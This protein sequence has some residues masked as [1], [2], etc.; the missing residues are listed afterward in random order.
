MQT[1]DTVKENL[2]NA[3]SDVAVKP[4]VLLVDDD[5]FL[6]DMYS[7][8]FTKKGYEV[9]TATDGSDAL[10]KIKDGYI[11]DVMV[12]DIIMPVMDGVKLLENIRAEKLIPNA[13]VVV[14]SNQGQHEDIER[15]QAFNIDGYIIKALTIPSEVIDQV[16]SLFRAK[17]IVK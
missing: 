6:L 10:N 14:L 15:A 16:D 3:S 2:I 1:D 4:K 8:K 11:P 7:L 12:C 5:K 13:A 9:N 17:V